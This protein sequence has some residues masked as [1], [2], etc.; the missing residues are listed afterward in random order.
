V[1]VEVA[2]VDE[3]ELVEEEVDARAAEAEAVLAVVRLRGPVVV[4]WERLR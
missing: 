2:A 1:A 3:V 4:P